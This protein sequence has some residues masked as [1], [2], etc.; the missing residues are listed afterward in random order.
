MTYYLCP[1]CMFHITQEEAERQADVNGSLE[2]PGCHGCNLERE[3]EPT[4][5][6]MNDADSSCAE[7]VSFSN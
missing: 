3:D 6:D 4:D 7:P 2:C 5:D 1:C